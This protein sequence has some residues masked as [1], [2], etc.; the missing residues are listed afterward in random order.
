MDAGAT[1]SFLQKAAKQEAQTL[2]TVKRKLER[3]EMQAEKDTQAIF[4][5]LRMLWL[6]S[7]GHPHLMKCAWRVRKNDLH[8]IWDP[9]EVSSEHIWNLIGREFAEERLSDADAWALMKPRRTK[10]LVCWRR[11]WEFF[12]EWQLACAV[13]QVNLTKKMVATAE[14]IHTKYHQIVNAAHPCMPEAARDHL[15]ATLQKR[16]TPEAARQWLCRWRQR[17]GFQ[18]RALPN[19]SFIPDERFFRKVAAVR[20]FVFGS[21]S[22]PDLGRG[23]GAIFG[24]WGGA[25]SYGGAPPIKGGRPIFGPKPIPPP[26]PIWSPLQEKKGK[27]KKNVFF[28]EKTPSHPRPPSPHRTGLSTSWLG[29]CCYGCVAATWQKT[30][31]SQRR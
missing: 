29:S 18:Y 21:T 17:W 7:S 23:A 30:G 14:Y 4:L 6:L 28:C 24:V 19:R 22:G 11:A 5:W 8:S 1:I 9:C 16:Q 3:A 26:Y 31:V 13:V 12:C 10:D 2:R 20:G 27:K 25:D 15:Q